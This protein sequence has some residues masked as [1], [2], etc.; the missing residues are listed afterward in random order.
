MTQQV[1]Y[2]PPQKIDKDSI[3]WKEFLRKQGEFR[4][5]DEGD[6]RFRTTG[7]RPV[8]LSG[9]FTPNVQAPAPQ[10]AAAAPQ[11]VT[12][13]AASPWGAS[14][15][16]FFNND[17]WTRQYEGTNPRT[18]EPISV[19]NWYTPGGGNA[20]P[21]NTAPTAAGGSAINNDPRVQELAKQYRTDYYRDLPPQTVVPVD[22]LDTQDRLDIPF[23]VDQSQTATTDPVPESW[24]DQGS[25]LAGNAFDYVKGGI[26]DLGDYV[27]ELKQPK[28]VTDEAALKQWLDAQRNAG[29]SN[30][31]GFPEYTGDPDEPIEF[32][33]LGGVLPYMLKSIPG[34]LMQKIQYI[35]SLGIF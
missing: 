17:N 25:E 2:H 10:P 19:G 3:E 20:A 22:S 16:D 11:P 4:P 30:P 15:S 29:V 27:G 1:H 18:G 35:K 13:H 28:P 23:R 34:N 33:T 26:G 31:K 5:P 21:V 12:G 6:P 9:A 32:T 8:D 14:I 7:N 24:W